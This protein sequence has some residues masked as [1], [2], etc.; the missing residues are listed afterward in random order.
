VI[1]ELPD[2]VSDKENLARFILTDSWLYKD[3]RG[4][5]P[6]RP[7]AFMPHPHLELSVYR[8]DGW[9]EDELRSKG[10]E[11]ASER[12]SKHRAAMLA[13]GRSYPAAKRTFRHLGRGE[14]V[15]GEVRKC[16]LDVVKNEPP[17]AHANIVGWPALSNN[18]KADEAAQMAFA[19]LLQGRVTFVP[20]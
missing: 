18:R 13:Q 7:N 8:I 2:R 1:R 19:L 9:T 6:L 16:G 17:I 3:D 5:C 10:E 14:I 4:G 20:P 15:T 12:E 11:I